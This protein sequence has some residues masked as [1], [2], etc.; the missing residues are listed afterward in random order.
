MI[1]LLRAQEKAA[2]AAFFLTNNT[3]EPGGV[4]ASIAS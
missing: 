2:E 3:G 1:P 4:K